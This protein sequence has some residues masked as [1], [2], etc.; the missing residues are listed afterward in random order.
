MS[1]NIS[2]F[3][4]SGVSEFNLPFCRVFTL[5]RDAIALYDSLDRK[6][7]NI[8]RVDFSNKANDKIIKCNYPVPRSV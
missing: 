6:F 3:V 7:K 5:K 8:N 4:N 2:Y 1:K